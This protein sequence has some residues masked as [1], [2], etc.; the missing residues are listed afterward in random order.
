MPELLHRPTRAPASTAAAPAAAEP[1]AARRRAVAWRHETLVFRLAMAAAALWVLDNAF[2]HREPGTAVGDHLASG[3]VPVALTGLLALAYPRLR[4]GARAVAALT[5][6]PLMILAGVVDGVRHIAVDR[7]A[8]DDVTAVVCG[9]GGAVLVG[10]GTAL[11]WQSRRLDERLVRRYARRP[12]T[13]VIAGLVGV[14]LVMPLG[15]AVVVNHKARAPVQRLDHG[16][17]YVDVTLTTS[18]GLRLAGWY[19]PSRNGAA[20]IAF[21]GRSGPVRHAR[22][23]VRHGY[24]VLLLDRR[25]EGRSEGDYNARGWGGEPD[26]RAAIAYLRTRSDVRD[27]RIGGLGLS[28]GGELL[29]QT[30]A[31][32]QGLRAVVSEGAGLRSVA[33]QKHMPGTPPEPLRWIAPITM[34]TVAGTVSDH[35]PPADLADL[36]LRIAPRPVLLIR[37]RSGNPDESLNR[38]YRRAG[39]PTVSLWEIPRAGHTAG[40]STVP[41][42]YE[43]RV[44][45]FFDQALLKGRDE[46]ARVWFA[47]FVACVAAAEIWSRRSRATREEKRIPLAC[48]HLVPEPMWQATRAVTIDA[49]LE[50][51]WPW[52]VQVGFPTHRAGWYTSYWLDRPLLGVAPPAPS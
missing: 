9:L 40:L 17:P 20:V 10:F 51:V 12:I 11:L 46:L 16:R 19:V 5:A 50:D 42:E 27:D 43:R 14:F 29:L 39:G 31:Q 48:D 33:E 36:M 8:G 18:D 49:G 22:M 7:L 45:S 15:F 35:R 30:A 25:G 37:G 34:E 38:T 13:A 2:W 1:S 3:L 23:L 26:L 4:P 21:P 52:L 41:A 32:D 28:V 6:G 24:G 44:V 47:G